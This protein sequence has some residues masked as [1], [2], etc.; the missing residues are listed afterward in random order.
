MTNGVGLNTSLL[1]GINFTGGNNFNMAATNTNNTASSANSLF[2]PVQ[3]T[4]NLY[5]DDFMMSGFD[6]DSL[7]Y[8][9]QSGTIVRSAQPQNRQVP[10]LQNNVQQ[11]NAGTLNFESLPQDIQQPGNL[12]AE[13][14]LSELDNYLV[15]NETNQQNKP[16][17]SGKAIC[18]TLGFLAPVGERV[19]AGI[20]SGGIMKALNWKQLAVTCPIIGLAGFGVGF[21][22]DK[23]MDSFKNKNTANA[24][25]T[26]PAEAPQQIQQAQMPPQQNLQLTV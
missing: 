11:N 2:N 8:D 13:Q 22:I 1:N 18:T 23:I 19:A 15:K 4:T 26:N 7:S 9:A 6:F 25:Q 16:S 21:V 3:S 12:P 14:N 20:K 5:S 24:P 17:N 10:Q